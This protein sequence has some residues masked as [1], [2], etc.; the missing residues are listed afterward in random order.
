[1]KLD[2]EMNIPESANYYGWK[3]LIN[4]M[5]F[6]ETNFRVLRCIVLNLTNAL[7]DA[8]KDAVN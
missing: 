5:E 8:F 3:Y 6:N 7:H 2:I 4:E 1:M